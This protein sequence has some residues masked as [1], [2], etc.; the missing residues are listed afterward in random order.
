M[1]S[2]GLVAAPHPSAATPPAASRTALDF[3]DIRHEAWRA[4]HGVPSPV[5]AMAQTPDGWLWLGTPTGL[6]RF[7]GV[8]LEP[9]E[10]L[11]GQPVIRERVSALHVDPAG[12]LWIGFIRNG[13]S[14]VHQGRLIHYGQ[15]SGVPDGPVLGLTVSRDGKTWA[16]MA[17][18]LHVLE[19]NRWQRVGPERAV[20]QV[21]QGVDGAIW[22]HAQNGSIY[23][24]RRGEAEPR[25]IGRSGAGDEPGNLLLG[26]DGTVWASHRGSGL[27]RFDV[28]GR[29]M[30]LP[31]SPT[32][33]AG[34]MLFDQDGVAWY[35]ARDGVKRASPAAWSEEP[36]F[37]VTHAPGIFTPFDG[38]SDPRIY[39][40]L[41]DREGN[42]W[43][44][45]MKGLDQFRPRRLHR[46]LR[47]NGH[48][49]AYAGINAGPHGDLFVMS[50]G[51]LL[52]RLGA[53]PETL[54][55]RGN[56]VMAFHVDP[57]GDVW[58]ASWQGSLSRLT[59]GRLEQIPLPELT[60]ARW[61]HGVATDRAGRPWIG[62]TAGIYQR[63]GDEWVAIS[64]A[65]PAS[66]PTG[67]HS[68]DA[69]RIWATYDDGR[70]EVFDEDRRTAYGR[71]Q[72]LD[73]GSL[74]VV[75]V[76]GPH[77]WAAGPSGMGLLAGGRFHP[78]RLA[79]AL[80]PGGTTGIVETA[81]ADVW[82]NGAGG[83][84][85]VPAAEVAR[86][87]SDP[88]YQ[89]E[90][91]HFN[92]SDGLEGLSGSTLMGTSSV[93]QT[94]DGRLWFATDL[95]LWWIDPKAIPR[96]PVAPAVSIR[97]A[98]SDGSFWPAHG[99]LH[100]PEGTTSLEI[101]Y[102]APSLSVPERV[103]FR[104][105]LDSDA[106]WQDVGNR[107]AAY[108]TQL[109]PGKHRFEVMASNE[110]GVWSDTPASFDFF[111]APAFYETM[112]FKAVCV[113]LFIA[114]LAF[115]YMMRVRWLTR[116]AAERLQ[117]VLSERERIAAEL[118]DTLLQGVHALLLRVQVVRSRLTEPTMQRLLD[119]AM[120]RAEQLVAEG[121]DRIAD[122]R[123]VR[124]SLPLADELRRL[125]DQLSR[126]HQIQFR[127]RADEIVD[128]E[129]S[130][131]DQEHLFYIA[132]EAVWNALRHARATLIEVDVEELAGRLC[133]RVRDDGIGLAEGALDTAVATGHWG[134][135][136]M[137][138]RAARIGA[139]VR[140][141]GVEGRGT[142]V[143]ILIPPL[144]DTAPADAP[145]NSGNPDKTESFEDSNL[146]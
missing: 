64:N 37:D 139:E 119:E 77:V 82:I 79:G 68:D 137:R 31:S 120:D 39:S 118:H 71:E 88:T 98:Q 5:L 2:W 41:Q 9:V 123:D 54:P 35:A 15:E 11:A 131:S 129:L 80:M 51:A 104:Y 141:H 69:A 48:D 117:A 29:E 27:R 125:L 121:R 18:G 10:Y 107:R 60:R 24:L 90:F 63:V 114:A 106:Q 73:I 45:T 17:R 93:A 113:E 97:G 112:W 52:A 58:A 12:D 46:V 56:D 74:T 7:D 85:R 21:L 16:A 115:A 111:I 50:S 43:V 127:L 62:A 136:G 76:R 44:G 4:R 91:E 81:E 57:R 72:G 94:G 145:A 142:T 108:Y 92:H 86:F 34:P 70:L 13:I 59:E 3:T 134:V 83:I 144:P 40:L 19:G 84:F 32:D 26:S 102:T 8:R 100:L 101:E 14:V 65:N 132:R 67:L 130:Q 49:Y 116:R 30:P 25:L 128:L 55:V 103:R 96:N 33:V 61:V 109:S 38:L 22:S 1:S 99:E 20:T 87:K 140:I 126:D 138:E 146:G 6:Y 124:Q 23:L 42:V 75:H 95:G 135:Q 36:A 78:L 105:R 66:R 133:V 89:P 110:D 47:E 122:L 143:E 53:M 28:Q